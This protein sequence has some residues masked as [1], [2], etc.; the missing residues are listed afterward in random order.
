MGTLRNRSVPF[1]QPLVSFPGQL[2]V[3]ERPEAGRAFQVPAC[4]PQMENTDLTLLC[5]A[6]NRFLLKIYING[7]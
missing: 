5:T 3:L 4:P 6:S 1:L 2:K 7:V